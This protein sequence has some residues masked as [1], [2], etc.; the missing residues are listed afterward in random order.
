MSKLDDLKAVVGEMFE[1]AESKEEIDRASKAQKLVDEAINEASV[2]QAEKAKLLKDY[3]EAIKYSV[4]DEKTTA[5][6][7][8]GEAPELIDFINKELEQNNK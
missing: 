6:E 8:T 5:D 2:E 7:P 1:K 3:K 4:A